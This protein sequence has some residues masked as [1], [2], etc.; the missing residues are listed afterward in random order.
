MV[1]AC[2][3]ELIRRRVNVLVVGCGGNGSAI[4][5]GLPYLHQALVAAGHPGG[6]H[7]TLMDGDTVSATNCVRQPFSVSEIGL[8]KSVV[9]ANRLNA[10]WGLDWT[11]IPTFLTQMDSLD[12]CDILIGAVDNRAT[13]CL[14]AEKTAQSRLFYWL[15]LGNHADGGQFVLGQPLNQRNRRKADRLRTVAELYP[16]ITDGNRD[17]AD[18]P[19]CSAVEAL[20]RQEPFVN[21]TLAY[22]ALGL[23][24]RLFRHGQVVYQGAFYSQRSGRS[25][26]L[27]LGRRRRSRKR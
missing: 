23:L 15:D 12:D 18:G 9:L 11:G 25:A 19:S 2:P 27:T 8:H 6:L 13:R 21:Q 10:F 14:I 16:E 17:A 4:A 26:G 24:A 1:H 5:G 3:E 20:D 7:V 22:S